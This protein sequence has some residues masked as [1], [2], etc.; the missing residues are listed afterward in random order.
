[1]SINVSASPLVFDTTISGSMPNIN[2]TADVLSF[3][4]RIKAVIS[5]YPANGRD[6][7]LDTVYDCLDFDRFGEDDQGVLVFAF[8]LSGLWL[9]KKITPNVFA[10]NLGISGS[11]VKALTIQTAQL[12][13]N[14]SISGTLLIEPAKTSWV[15]WSDIGNINFD[16]NHSNVAGERPMDWSGEIY[17]ILKFNNSVLIYGT[18]GISVM[19]PVDVSWKYQTLSRLGTKGR[20]AQI[21]NSSNTI[22]WFIDSKGRLYELSDGLKKLDYSEYLSLMSGLVL[23]LDE[24]NNFLYICDGTYGYIYN[25]EERSLCKGPVNISGFGIQ[26][27]VSYVVA[28]DD[29][30]NPTIEFETDIYDLG[31]RKEKTIFNLE[32]STNVNELMEASISYRVDHK[33]AFVQLPWVPITPQGIAYLNCYGREFKFH[34]R[35]TEFASFSLDQVKINGVIH[36]F[37]FLDTIRKEN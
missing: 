17:D 9:N 22:H 11:Y 28:D 32:F 30:V 10:F 18:N 26:N 33:A 21:S 35:M 13:F 12:G 31:T 36:G 15:K 37:S 24:Y 8:G 2:V 5:S 27:A 34:F 6:P 14:L 7:N 4:T 1:M 20:H 25:Y 19:S 3:T 16:I 29:I 23:S